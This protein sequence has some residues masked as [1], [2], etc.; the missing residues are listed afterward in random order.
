MKLP[1]PLFVVINPVMRLLL[2]SPL[3]GV[4][5]DSIMLVTFTG[6]KSGREYTTPV[7]YVRMG[8]VIRC[9]SSDETMWWRNLRNGARAKLRTAGE[10]H[11][12]RTEVI[13]KEPDKIKAALEHYFSVYPQ[14][15]DYHDVKLDRDRRPVAADLE[16]AAQKAVV[17]EARL[18]AA[19]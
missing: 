5:S 3:H 11:T 19:A 12:Y 6:V 9:Y 1:E 10:V 15:A 7:R 8:D 18:D 4:L 16:A 17:V 2:C 13:E 14:D